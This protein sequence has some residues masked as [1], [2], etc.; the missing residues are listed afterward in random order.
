MVTLR[1]VALSA[2]VSVSTASRAL[3]R[4]ERVNSE[5]RE[6]VQAVA[7]DLGYRSRSVLSGRAERLAPITRAGMVGLLVPDVTNPFYFGLIRGTQEELRR[8][9]T[10]H[11][12]A[13][14]EEA[15]DVENAWL[16]RLHTTVDGIVLGASRLSDDEIAAWSRRVP[17]VTV[18]RAVTGV[19]TVTLDTPLGYAHAL[20]HLAS[21]GHQRVAYAGGPPT[22][23]SDVRRL[24]ML[25]SRSRRLGVELV[26]LGAYPPRASAGAA[27]AD[28]A[29]HAD[30]TAV[31]TFNDMVAIGVIA[32]LRDRNVT[33]PGQ[34]SV[35]GCD[36]AYGADLS[37]PPLTTITAPVEQA[38][39][40]AARLLL[41]L[42]EQRASGAGGEHRRAGA[43][44]PSGPA[45]DALRVDLP[46]H[47]TI[48]DSTGPVRASRRLPRS[49]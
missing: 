32:R 19:P 43:S 38:G 27:V 5:T 26:A 42:V 36:D 35:V 8:T 44:A 14:T 9:S 10:V 33:V 16:E 1:D 12:L 25:R 49:S 28:A 45:P 37:H 6:R 30:V 17:V 22:A 46:T 2:G 7:L 13:D 23:W 4:P 48:R 29:V 47:L 40:A 18:N 31:L 15:A 34:M 3:H 21:L 20:D 39:A 41:D 11:I 24:R